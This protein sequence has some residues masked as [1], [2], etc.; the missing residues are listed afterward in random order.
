MK[1]CYIP[2]VIPVAVYY[3]PNGVQKCDP[4]TADI[5][6]IGSTHGN[7]I[8]GAAA[9]YYLIETNYFS[10]NFPGLN[11]IIIPCLNPG[12]VLCYRRNFMGINDLNRMYN[13]TGKYTPVYKLNQAV[14]NMTSRVKLVIDL[15]E[16]WGY[17]RDNSGSIGSTISTSWTRPG[18]LHNTCTNAKEF[19][20]SKISEPRKHFTYISCKADIPGT[21]SYYCK[22][23]GIPHVLIETS[24]Q[25][26]IQPLGIRVNQMVDIIG[27]II[28]DFKR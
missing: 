23:R 11:F 9:L 14:Q 20:N 1:K 5:L 3:T 21:L 25:N 15:H 12:G 24:G 28:R 10:V 6:L 13:K 17:Y 19:V 2:G 7:E 16:G 26:E 22:L 27:V 18:W 4:G 8:A